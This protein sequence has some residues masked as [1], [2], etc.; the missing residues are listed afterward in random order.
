MVA[1]AGSHVVVWTQ[2][3]NKKTGL[4][5][6]F[7]ALFRIPWLLTY[8]RVRRHSSSQP[9]V[10]LLLSLCPDF[11]IFGVNSLS[12]W[13][14][15]DKRTALPVWRKASDQV[16][17]YPISVASMASCRAFGASTCEVSLYNFEYRYRDSP[18][19]HR[20]QYIEFGYGTSTQTFRTSLK[21]LFRGLQS[22]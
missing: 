11:I 12:F 5:F 17:A 6:G 13:K 20:K 4:S 18:A 14:L 16:D 10:S 1:V 2:K 9:R 3:N 15:D 21:P 8:S 22:Y 19:V 7:Q